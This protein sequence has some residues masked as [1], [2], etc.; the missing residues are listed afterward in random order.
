MEAGEYGKQAGAE[1]QRL[2]S[3]CDQTVVDECDGNVMDPQ[4]GQWAE[5]GRAQLQDRDIGQDSV[6]GSQG[7]SVGSSVCEEAKIER[8]LAEKRLSQMKKAAE[9][10]L[11]EE[12]LRLRNELAEAEEAAELARTKEQLVRDLEEASVIGSVVQVDRDKRPN[13]CSERNP[14]VYRDAPV[15]STNSPM[16]QPVSVRWPAPTH[17]SCPP[18]RLQHSGFP[19]GVLLKFADNMEQISIKTSLPPLE[20]IKFTGDPCE[21]FWFRARFNEMVETMWLSDQQ[22]M[23]R[24]LQ[25]L[26]GKARKAVAGLEGVPGG[27]GQSLRILEGRY[28]QPHMVAKACVDTLQYGPNI[29]NSDKQGLRDFADN[30]RTIFET[31]TSMNALSELNMTSLGKIAGRLPFLLQMKWRDHAQSIRES[32]RFPGMQHLVVFIEKAADAVNDPV[33]GQ[34]GEADRGV[35]SVHRPGRNIRVSAR[36]TT[37]TTQHI[38]AQEKTH[39]ANGN[40]KNGN[41][42][43]RHQAVLIVRV[44]ISWSGAENSRART[45]DKGMPL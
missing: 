24:L 12:E 6:S 14:Q 2:G 27:F 34:I 38:G 20:I 44:V 11:Q 40:Q 42:L 28:G 32:G 39:G 30:V 15:T 22:K 4:A 26:D 33:F 10:K 13:D 35:K 1:V 31:L 29:A 17:T 19:D 21:Y 36:A 41:L 5:H 43:T 3:H 45:L 7:K 23:S 37:L 18:R 9:R 8:I 16:S 25:F